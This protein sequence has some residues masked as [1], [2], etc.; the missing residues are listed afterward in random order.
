MGVC[1]GGMF[2]CSKLKAHAWLLHNWEAQA[3]LRHTQ[4]ASGVSLAGSECAAHRQEAKC[5]VDA[6]PF[7]PQLGAKG[8]PREEGQASQARG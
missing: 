2:G 5:R 3:W 8:Q 4:G 1:A 7:T 6:S